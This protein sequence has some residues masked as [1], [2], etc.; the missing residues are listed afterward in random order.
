MKGLNRNAEKLF[1]GF[2]MKR[3][4]KEKF[5]KNSYRGYCGANREQLYFQSRKSHASGFGKA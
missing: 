2:N 3:R 4:Q 1:K 5:E